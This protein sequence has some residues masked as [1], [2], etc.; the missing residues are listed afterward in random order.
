MSVPGVITAAVIKRWDGRRRSDFERGNKNYVKKKSMPELRNESLPMSALVA[1]CPPCIWDVLI[2]NCPSF[3][4][5]ICTD[6]Y[7]L[8]L[9]GGSEG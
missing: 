4:M 1:F 2:K 3:S 8:M 6:A 7:S 9:T 5:C